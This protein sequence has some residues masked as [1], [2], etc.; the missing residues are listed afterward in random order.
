MYIENPT[1][2]VPW[3]DEDLRRFVRSGIS[4]GKFVGCPRATFSARKLRQEEWFWDFVLLIMILYGL[5]FLALAFL[6]LNFFGE[7]NSNQTRKR[8]TLRVMISIDHYNNTI[9]KTPTSWFDLLLLIP[10]A[11][12]ILIHTLVKHGDLIRAGVG[13]DELRRGEEGPLIIDLEARSCT[14]QNFGISTSNLGPNRTKTGEVGQNA[15]GLDEHVTLRGLQTRVAEEISGFL[16]RGTP[17]LPFSDALRQLRLGPN[18]TK[19]AQSRQ[20]VSGQKCPDS[21]VWGSSLEVYYQGSWR[22]FAVRLAHRVVIVAANPAS[23]RDLGNAV[24]DSDNGI[25]GVQV[26]TW[27][28]DAVNISLN[29]PIEVGVFAVGVGLK[30]KFTKEY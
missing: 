25:I 27:T 6:K 22:G 18:R 9:F 2:A 28:E 19:I 13:S 1:V 21:G 20:K 23:T 5:Y 7:E 26:G 24:T 3:P 17:K 12:G 10:S 30:E 4:E 16:G 8:D 29:D 14:G 15:R 11:I